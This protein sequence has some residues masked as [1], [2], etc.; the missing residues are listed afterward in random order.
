MLKVHTS[1]RK[2]CDKSLP[3]FCGLFGPESDWALFNWAVRA[4]VPPHMGPGGPGGA[5]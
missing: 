5:S 3:S 2:T 4:V 1:Q